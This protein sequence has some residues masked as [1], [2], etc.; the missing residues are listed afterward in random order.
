MTS[1]LDV[2]NMPR[3]APLKTRI[4]WLDLRVSDEEVA[5]KMRQIALNGYPPNEDLLDASQCWEVVE[6]IVDES[7]KINRHLDLRLLSNS[8]EDRLQAEDHEAGCSWQDLVASR[9]RERPSIAAQLQSP[10]MRTHKRDL[11]LRIARE[12]VGLAPEERLRVWQEKVPPPGNS[13]ATMYRRLHELAQVDAA[14]FE[15]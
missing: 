7:R 15:T 1:N 5:A 11:E 3:L 4:S 8:F 2:R 12:I 10:D 9:L 14:H 6:F 13:R